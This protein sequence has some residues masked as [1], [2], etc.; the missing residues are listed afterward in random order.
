[1]V[2]IKRIPTLEAD[3]TVQ[4]LDE[5]QVITKKIPLD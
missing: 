2:Q 1:M 3:H 4:Y 5:I